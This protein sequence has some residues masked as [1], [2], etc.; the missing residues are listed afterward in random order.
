MNSPSPTTGPAKRKRPPSYPHSEQAAR[1]VLL[2]LLLVTAVGLWTRPL[3]WPVA[4]P[5]DT[6]YRVRI[7]HAPA[8]ELTLLPGIGPKLAEAVVE[9]RKA[10]GVYEKV[11]ELQ[12]VS[13]IGPKTVESIRPWVAL[14]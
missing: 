8:A 10:N 3:S 1:L 9:D 7:N 6:G 5:E 14:E 13:R 12:R 11:D 4:Q 2:A